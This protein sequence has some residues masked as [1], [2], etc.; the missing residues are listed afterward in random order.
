MGWR[1][2]SAVKPVQIILTATFQRNIKD[3]LQSY[4]LATHYDPAWYKAWHTW[5]LANFEVVS[6]LEDKQYHKANEMPGEELAAHIVSAVTGKLRA[7]R[8]AGIDSFISQAS[9]ALSRYGTKML[10]RIRCG[11]LRSG[12][13]SEPMTMSAMQWLQA[14]PTLRSTLGSKSYHR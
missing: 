11:C 9:S 13:S 3:I 2:Y 5:A 12:S 4:Y 10:Y 14:S 6:F 1:E 8:P 7:L